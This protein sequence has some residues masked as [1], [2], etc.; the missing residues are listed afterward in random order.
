MQLKFSIFIIAFFSSSTIYSE[1]SENRRTPNSASTKDKDA[2]QNRKNLVYGNIGPIPYLFSM[3]LG[4][5]R[6]MNKLITIVAD[7]NYG[8]RTLLDANNT[9]I[10]KEQD[11]LQLDEKFWLTS[12][13]LRIY[14]METPFQ[15][16][17]ASLIIGY[18]QDAMNISKGSHINGT[19]I[20]GEVAGSKQ[21]SGIALGADVGYSFRTDSAVFSLAFGY[22]FA[23][24]RNIP[25]TIT[26]NGSVEQKNLSREIGSYAF[27]ARIT[28]A[29]GYAF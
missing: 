10:Y 27:A 13:A 4:Y 9:S 28:I 2:L 11:N 29:M 1:G 5:Q 22:N 14:S 8:Q 24:P 20:Q 26:N 17:Y 19:V 18:Y 7:V 6:A 15:G 25:Y 3:S 23:L 16:L 21:I 12:L